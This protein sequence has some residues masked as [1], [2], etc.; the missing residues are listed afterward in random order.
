MPKYLQLFDNVAQLNTPIA[1]TDGQPWVGAET[2]TKKVRYEKTG[3]RSGSLAPD[4]GEV[5]Q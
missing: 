5:E 1:T 4:A 2:S 3:V